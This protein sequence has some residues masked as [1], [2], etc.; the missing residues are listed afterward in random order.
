MVSEFM[1]G[2]TLDWQLKASYDYFKSNPKIIPRMALDIV[3]G[4][5]K[6]VS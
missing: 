3:K 4:T 6:V 2:G 5:E 1:N